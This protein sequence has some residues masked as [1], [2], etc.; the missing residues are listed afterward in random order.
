[1]EATALYCTAQSI[2]LQYEKTVLTDQVAV[3]PPLGTSVTELL[4][5][6]QSLLV[7]VDRLGSQQSVIKQ[8]TFGKATCTNK[9]A[10]KNLLGNLTDRQQTAELVLL[11]VI[12][13]IGEY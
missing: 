11:L 7:E 12:W 1:M 3:C 4:G 9:V 6:L 5:D 13:N 2:E 10:K 8:R